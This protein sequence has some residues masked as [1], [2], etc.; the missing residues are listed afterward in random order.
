[1]SVIRVVCAAVF[2]SI[3]LKGFLVGFLAIFCPLCPSHLTI[4][5]VI[6]V[7]PTN[8]CRCDFDHDA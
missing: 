1:M 2:F 8:G 3:F 4:D 5:E 6:R 7:W